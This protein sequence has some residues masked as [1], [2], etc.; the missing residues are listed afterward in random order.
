MNLSFLNNAFL[1]FLPLTLIPFILHLL[2]KKKP[3][4]IAF[5]HLQFLKLASKH[6]IPRSRLQHWLLLLIRALIILLL[7]LLFSRPIL[8]VGGAG[9]TGEENAFALV[10]IIDASYSM[11]AEVNGKTIYDRARDAGIG[12]INSLRPIDRACVLIYSN[13]LENPSP[14]LIGDKEHLIQILKNT[15][16]SYRTTEVIPGMAKAFELLSESAAVNKGIV[17]LGDNAAHGWPEQY[18]NLSEKIVHFDDKVHLVFIDCGLVEDNLYIKKIDAAPDMWGRNSS[19]TWY[20]HNPVNKRF[21]EKDVS[22]FL[23]NREISSRGIVLKAHQTSSGVVPF[24]AAHGGIIPG[25]LLLSPD[26]LQEDNQ[27]YFYLE[28]QE[29]ISVLSVDGDPEMGT[30]RGETYF[31]RT[32]LTRY[33]VQSGIELKTINQDEFDEIK[34]NE[35]Q[36]ILLCNVD[37]VT[38]KAAEKLRT[39]ITEGGGVGIFPGERVTMQTY[40]GMDDLLPAQFERVVEAAGKPFMVQEETHNLKSFITGSEDSSFELDKIA[41]KKYVKLREKAGS[42]VPLRVSSRDPFLVMSQGFLHHVVMLSLPIDAD[43]SNLPAKPLYVP[44]LHRIVGFLAGIDQNIYYGS[45]NVGEKIHI[46]LPSNAYK[47]REVTSSDG[48][49]IQV[50]QTGRQAVIDPVGQPCHYIIDCTE[51]KLNKQLF[52][53]VNINRSSNEGD[54]QKISHTNIQKIFPE[55]MI[56]FLKN[57]SSVLQDVMVA[58]RGKE[59]SRSLAGILL[60]LLIVEL[61]LA[62]IGGKKKLLILLCIFSG[63]INPLVYGEQDNRFAYAQ[64]KYDGGWNPYPDIHHEIL[65]FMVTTTSIKVVSGKKEVMLSSKDIFEYPFLILLGNLQFPELTDAMRKELVQ[66]L[67]GG[68][69]LFI[70]DST[71]AA[72]SAFD[73]GARKEIFKMFPQNPLEIISRDHAVMRSFYLL[74]TVAGRKTIHNYIEGVE[75]NGRVALLYSQNDILGAW[76]RDRL[77]NYMYTIEPGGEKQRTEAVKLTANIILFALTGTYKTDAIHIPFI[78]Q[79]LRSHPY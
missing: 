54:M 63:S 29:K 6:A 50:A 12:I 36:V 37:P 7:I 26:A 69:V 9:E 15:P 61:M 66:Y 4:R 74:R 2:F 78:L 79:K 13:R 77:G 48:S 39:F 34:L 1:Y 35:Y 27:F 23:K 70:E 59:I 24:K 19:V 46:M 40:A 17:Y 44:M 75:V 14:A 41:V 3:V 42:S 20:V 10:V 32:A 57:G 67:E 33:Q 43:W 25:K 16:A 52:F 38:P 53:A 18:E 31:M 49:K 72:G 58:L 62:H 56:T 11:R 76:A 5:S 55:N 68:G 22:V 51:N 45:F 65:S 8:H 64:I 30:V 28:A 71:G 21:L 47:V 73:R 60:V